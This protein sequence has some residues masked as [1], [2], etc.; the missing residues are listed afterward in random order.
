MHLSNHLVVLISI[1]YLFGLGVIAVVGVDRLLGFDYR[2]YEKVI[3]A[4][5]G[6]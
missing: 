4:G 5:V 3:V 6:G 1:R 2:E